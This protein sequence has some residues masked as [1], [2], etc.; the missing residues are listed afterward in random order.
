M[1]CENTSTPVS[2]NRGRTLKRGAQALVGESRWHAHVD[3]SHVRAVRGNGLDERITVGYGGRD[4]M[5]TLGRTGAEGV[6]LT[7]V[8]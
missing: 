5:A 1:Y 2:G 4:V 7:R 6:A 8:R 3:H